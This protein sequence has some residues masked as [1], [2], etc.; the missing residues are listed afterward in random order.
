VVCCADAVG[1][2]LAGVCMRL[3][4]VYCHQQLVLD[5]F[6]VDS[7]VLMGAPQR[8]S[9]VAVACQRAVL[10]VAGLGLCLCDGHCASTAASAHPGHTR[11][12]VQAASPL[13]LAGGLLCV[14]GGHRVP[15]VGVFVAAACC[16]L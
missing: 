2:L 15:W 13:G 4:V 7:A 10:I 9:S 11:P 5:V 6:A 16:R 8:H 3:W 12:S 1:L 14:T